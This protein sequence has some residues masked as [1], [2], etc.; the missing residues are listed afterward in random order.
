MKTKLWACYYVHLSLQTLL[1]KL[2]LGIEFLLTCLDNEVGHHYLCSMV[3]FQ[4]LSY[5]LDYV[6]ILYSLPC[7]RIQDIQAVPPTRVGRACILVSLMLDRTSE[8]L[9]LRDLKCS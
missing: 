3:S 5:R 1:R 9:G 6:P 2:L 4:I 8:M 7:Y